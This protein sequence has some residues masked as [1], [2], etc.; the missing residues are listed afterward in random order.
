MSDDRTDDGNIK[1][2]ISWSSQFINGE[3]RKGFLRRV[4]TPVDFNDP[5]G[6][7]ATD[8]N[9]TVVERQLDQLEENAQRHAK[10]LG[11]ISSLEQIHESTEDGG[12]KSYLAGTTADPQSP[13]EFAFR[14][15]SKI[16][17]IKHRL[18]R[19]PKDDPARETVFAILRMALE[20]GSSDHFMFLA[21][22][23]RKLLAGR[24]LYKDNSHH[25]DEEKK[26]AVNELRRRISNGEKSTQV[27]TEIGNRLGLTAQA[28]YGWRKKY[29]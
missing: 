1:E 13:F 16:Q 8:S 9:Q 29:E 4:T 6:S 7:T 10:A 22:H 28:I 2:N 26:L 11:Y 5:E 21:E 20:M 27:A 12:K 19:I 18:Q 15:E 14:V 3:K 24:G 25:S 23:E 17:N